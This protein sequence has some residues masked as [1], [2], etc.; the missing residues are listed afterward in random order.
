M[1]PSSGCRF[2]MFSADW[3]S[4]QLILHAKSPVK[5]Q[6]KN[7]IAATAMSFLKYFYTFSRHIGVEMFETLGD[8]KVGMDVGKV[9]GRLQKT[10]SFILLLS[11]TFFVSL[12]ML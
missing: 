5:I 1:C 3:K 8:G 2:S 7:Q 11:H 4:F 12:Q 6:R 9:M 10:Y